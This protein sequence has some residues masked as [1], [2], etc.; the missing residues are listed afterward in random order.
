MFLGIWPLAL[1]LAKVVLPA[2]AVDLIK[3][4]SGPRNNLYKCNEALSTSSETL[5]SRHDRP[6]FE[7]I[8]DHKPIVVGMRFSTKRKGRI[9]AVR[10]IQS[11]GDDGNHPR[12]GR[13]FSWP[14]GSLLGSTATVSPRQCRGMTWVS[15]SLQNP[16]PVE[17]NQVFVVAVENLDTYTETPDYFTHSKECSSLRARRGAGVSSYQPG[18]MPNTLGGSNYW[19]DG[20]SV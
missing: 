1:V 3:Q 19:V 10:Y 9:T 4:R 16:I 12:T 5:F 20:E 15:M 6:Q 11:S 17:P 8:R 18:S 13:L 14:D 2:E 7:N